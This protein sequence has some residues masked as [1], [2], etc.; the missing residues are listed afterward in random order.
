VAQ[1]LWPV[2]MRNRV[3][4]VPLWELLGEFPFG[5]GGLLHVLLAVDAGVQGRHPDLLVVEGD[6]ARLR[7]LVVVPQLQLRALLLLR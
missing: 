5:G 4:S 1:L 7:L 2:E 6:G 3:I